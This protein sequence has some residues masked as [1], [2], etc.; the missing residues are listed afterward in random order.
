MYWYLSDDL[1]QECGGSE[2]DKRLEMM[3]DDPDVDL[4][5]DRREL[6]PGRNSQFECFWKELDVLLENWEDC[7]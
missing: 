4:V 5:V 3:L 7:G 1:S 2:M 6:N